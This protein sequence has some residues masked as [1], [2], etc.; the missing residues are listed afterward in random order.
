MKPTAERQTLKVSVN[1]AWCKACGIC[2]EFCPKKALGQNDDDKAVWKHPDKCIR[3]GL[4]EQRCPD[5][6]IELV[7]EV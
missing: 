7:E 2:I 3:C 5:F 1:T 4:C 6:A